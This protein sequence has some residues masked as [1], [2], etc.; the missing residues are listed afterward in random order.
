MRGPEC[1]FFVRLSDP[2]FI[3]EDFEFSL[4]NVFVKMYFPLTWLVSKIVVKR[5][6]NIVTGSAVI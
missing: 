3:R 4:S 6:G 1:E 5:S 2:R